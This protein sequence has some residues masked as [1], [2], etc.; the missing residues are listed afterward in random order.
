[1]IETP[2]L[3]KMKKAK[4]DLGTEYIGAFIEWLAWQGYDVCK[5]QDGDE[6][7]FPFFYSVEEW[8][9][10]YADVDLVEVENER[11]ALL[12]ELRESGEN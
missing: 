6:E 1:M 11:R 8:L 9:A 10:L 7:W 12:K 2:A 3:D 4:E 5:Y